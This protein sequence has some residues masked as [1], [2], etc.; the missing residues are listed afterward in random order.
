ML[1]QK[2]WNNSRGLRAAIKLVPCAAALAWSSS[3]W[4]GIIVNDTFKDG[5]RAYPPAP[6]YSEGGTDHDLDGDVE[7]AWYTSP[8]AAMAATPGHL[9]MTQQ[10]GSSSYTS[11][12]TAEGKE[13]NL[14]HV[15][16][17][18]KV[19]WVFT[20][21]AAAS[22][23]NTSQ[24]LHIGLVDSP[25]AVT[26]LSADG[27]PAS[28]AYAGYGVYMNMSITAPGG[29][30]EPLG[31]SNP[32]RLMERDGSNSTILNNT[33]PPW[34]PLANGATTGNHGFDSGTQY[35]FTMQLTHNA[36]D[37]LDIVTRMS[38]GTVDGDGLEEVIFTDT[39]PNTFKYDTFALRPSSAASTADS[40]DT[41]LFKVE[42]NVPEP[43]SLLLMG[44]GGLGLGLLG[45]RRQ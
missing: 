34:N 39:T 24:N 19:T 41:T 35:T 14:A 20:P 37:G 23:T 10:S 43:A 6:G 22:Q 13:I 16:D 40:F 3:S 7:S 9:T 5:D 42:S 21:T 12:F 17:T 36:S 44:L 29:A 8:G 15:N 18:L 30:S 33:T 4:A 25:P 11:Y 1:L 31:N 45:R 28:G 38:G 26:R 32:F 2:W 27:T